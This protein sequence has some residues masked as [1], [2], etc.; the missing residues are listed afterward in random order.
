MALQL[1]AN[2]QSVDCNQKADFRIT[3]DCGED[4]DVQVLEICKNHY[5]AHDDLPSGEKFYYFKEFAK[6]VEVLE[7]MTQ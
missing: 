2:C 4:E 1:V 7:R 3:Y 6:K 5:E